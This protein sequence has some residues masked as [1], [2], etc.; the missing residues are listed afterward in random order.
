MKLFQ[1]KGILQMS[2]QNLNEKSNT[3]GFTYYS[4]AVF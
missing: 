4:G 2:K 1:N 3:F